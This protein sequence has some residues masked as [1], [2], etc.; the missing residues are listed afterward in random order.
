VQLAADGLPATLTVVESLGHERHLV[1][2][3]DDGQM[4]IVRVD[5]DAPV[6]KAMSH[7]HLATDAAHL[8]LFDPETTL[9]LQ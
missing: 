9:R 2:R 4:V 1:C 7:V 5:A 6:P 8:H 3:L